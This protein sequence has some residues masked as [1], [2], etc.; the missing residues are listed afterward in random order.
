MRG[1]RALV[2]CALPLLTLAVA[3]AFVFEVPLEDPLWWL[4]NEA[5]PRLSIEGPPG[6]VRGPIQARLALEPASRARITSARLDEQALSVAEGPV[7]ID[8]TTLRDGPHR[9][10]VVAHDTSRRRNLARTNWTFA[11]DNTPP[12]IELSVDP[13]EGPQ[14]GRAF[15]VRVRSDEPLH[16]LR[17]TIDGGALRLQSGGGDAFWAIHGIAPGAAPPA[18]SVRAAASDAIGNAAEVQ[19]QWPVRP[20]AFGQ[21][22]LDVEPSARELE[23]HVAEDRQLA[24]IY[25]RSDGARR[26][27]GLFR[28]PVAGPVSTPFGTRRSYEYHPGTDFAESLGAPVLAPAGGLVAYV[29][30]VPARGNIVILDHGAGVYSTYAHL[31]RAE[32]EAGA[33]VRMGQTIGRVGSSGFSTGPHLHWE[34]W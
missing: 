16:D 19:R 17:A 10:E 33:A 11:S 7:T 25:R 32:V 28:L 22:D 24:E 8:T 18:I 12:R 20:A 15:V 1:L 9:L 30:S 13:A 6:P 29:G 4:T 21:D 5:P 14:E 2:I 23:A 31:L 26:W 27:E 34:L 3:L